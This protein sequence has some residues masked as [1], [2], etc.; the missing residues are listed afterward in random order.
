MLQSCDKLVGL[1][2]LIVAAGVFTYYSA[3][4]LLVPFLDDNNILQSLF[5]PRDYAIKIPIFLL[6]LFAVGVGS[7]ISKVLIDNA[8]KEQ[9]KNRKKSE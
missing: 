5:L 7:F 6:L 1:G 3:W 2:M 9:I 4:V 8:K